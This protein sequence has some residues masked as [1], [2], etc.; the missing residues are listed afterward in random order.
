MQLMQWISLAERE[1]HVAFSKRLTMAV[2]LVV[3]AANNVTAH[4]PVI[5]P[6]W[7]G[8]GSFFFLDFPSS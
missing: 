3:A 6:W 1:M 5:A 4:A 7:H 8:F 2:L